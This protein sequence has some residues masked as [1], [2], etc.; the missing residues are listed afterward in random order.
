MI[1]YLMLT[2][3]LAMLCKVLCTA[4]FNYSLLL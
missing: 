4:M 3:I 2:L 1:T